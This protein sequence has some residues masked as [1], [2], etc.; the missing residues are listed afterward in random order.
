MLALRISQLL[1]IQLCAFDGK[2]RFTPT[3]RSNFLANSKMPRDLG[4]YSLNII[5]TTNYEISND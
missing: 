5:L 4:L 1:D 2:Q 3:R